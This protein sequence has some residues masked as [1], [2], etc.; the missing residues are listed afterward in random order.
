ML[1][2]LICPDIG[3]G[4]SAYTWVVTATL[5]T[6]TISTPIWG[7][8]ADLFSRKQ[9]LQLGIVIFIVGSVLARFATM[10]VWLIGCRAIQGVGAG[11][12]TALV[13][14]ILSD[15][16]SARERGR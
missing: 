1:E 14:V 16:V 10:S 6:M 12:L 8:M 13:Q 5:L 3:G 15:L 9:L 11:A 4:Q 7:K 2:E